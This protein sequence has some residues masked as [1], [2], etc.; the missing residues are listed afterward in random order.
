MTYKYEIK[1]DDYNAIDKKFITKIELGD[2]KIFE[3]NK[4][5]KDIIRE[6]N[7]TVDKQEWTSK[8]D[9]YVS[10]D[11][12]PIA[13]GFLTQYSLSFDNEY[14]KNYFFYLLDKYYLDLNYYETIYELEPCIQAGSKEDR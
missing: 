13:E 12:Q 6:S 14:Q 5:I 2:S 1:Y 9:S 8:Y 10:Y 7:A 11:Y 4:C 3:N